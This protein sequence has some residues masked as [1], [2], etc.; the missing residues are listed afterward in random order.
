MECPI[1]HSEP[2]SAETNSF[3]FLPR[4]GISVRKVISAE[5][6]VPYSLNTIT[7]LQI[8]KIK[9]YAYVRF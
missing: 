3:F 8:S 4:C 6:Y 7:S 5:V 9:N 2:F 1:L